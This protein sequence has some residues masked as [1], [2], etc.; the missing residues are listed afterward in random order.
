MAAF[1]FGFGGFFEGF[2][3]GG[4]GGGAFDA[5]AIHEYAGGAQLKFGVL[6]LVGFVGVE[7]G[8]GGFGSSS[9]IQGNSVRGW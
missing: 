4:G 3:E 7:A 2:V 9:R 5:E 6:L 1:L 8:A